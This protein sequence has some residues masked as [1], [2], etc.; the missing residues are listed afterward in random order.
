METFRRLYSS[1][2]NPIYPPLCSFILFFFIYLFLLVFICLVNYRLNIEL[3][4]SLFVV[5][6]LLVIAGY[7]Y[8]ELCE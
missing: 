7:Y 8:A 3:I 6:S 2:N 4:R 5:A 1:S